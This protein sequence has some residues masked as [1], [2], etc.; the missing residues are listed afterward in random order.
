MK[1]IVAALALSSAATPA[2]AHDFWIAP[3]QY[4]SLEKS[5]VISAEFRIGSASAPEDWKLMRE[6]IV[7]LRSIGPDGVFDQQ[8]EITPGQ[9]GKAVLRL[10][11]AGSHMVTLESS[12]SEIELTAPE[13]NAY[14]DHEGLDLVREWR[15]RNGQSDKPGRELYARR[16]KA[17]IQ[18]GRRITANV[19]QPV[20]L[21]LEIVPERSPHALRKEELLV[22]RLY[23][24]GVPLAG[25]TL[26]CESLSPVGTHQSV[27]TDAEGRA[28][29]AISPT[30]SWKIATVWSVPISANPR[31]D[32]DT[33]FASLTFGY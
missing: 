31:A 14:L 24:R 3:A 17:I 19:T 32:F 9:P 28:R 6:K 4:H 21:S 29:F 22:V 13:F 11:G 15:A 33:L 26:E 27:K 30:G 5:A 18:L 8:A 25:A 2:C 7:A 10:K 16:A 20:G 12:P 1:F 23:F